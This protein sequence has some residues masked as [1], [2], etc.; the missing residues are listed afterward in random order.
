MTT[1]SFAFRKLD[2]VKQG[3]TYEIF[4]PVSISFM[5]LKWLMKG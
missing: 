5:A 1:Y 2:Q 3:L 4:V